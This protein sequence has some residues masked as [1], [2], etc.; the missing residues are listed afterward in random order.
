MPSCPSVLVIACTVA[1]LAGAAGCINS[2][3]P[4]RLES[5]MDGNLQG[6]MKMQGD[7]RLQGDMAMDMNGR[8]ETVLRLDGPLQM[9][10][11]MQGPTVR[12]EGTFISDDLLERV[13]VDRTTDDWLI[14]VLGEPDVRAKLRDG[15]EIWRWTYK[16]VVQQ[17]DMI[18]IFGGEEKDPK[19]A[20]R[21]VFIHLRDGVVIEKWKG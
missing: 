2:K 18:E 3:E 1:A 8:L 21:T 7:M 9:T 16:P 12:Y 13:R 6:D 15:T 10:V 4:M 19:L 5:K 17:V 11:Q 14:A 20:S